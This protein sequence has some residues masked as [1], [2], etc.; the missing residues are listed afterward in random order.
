[1]LNPKR[2]V[3]NSVT[4]QTI[5]MTCFM[6]TTGNAV[7]P[8][9]GKIL[10][11]KGQ[12]IAFMGDSITAAGKRKG[13]YCQ[14]VLSALKDQGI[15]AKPVFAGISGHKSNQMLARLEH[16]IKYIMRIWM[17]ILMVVWCRDGC[18]N[19]LLKRM[20]PRMLPTRMI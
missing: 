17:G 6:F 13:G 10:V 4:A 7:E 14:L 12:K 9:S 8:A 5:L 19:Q 18:V 16:L 11:K 15:E 20:Y 3:L 2:S 1:M